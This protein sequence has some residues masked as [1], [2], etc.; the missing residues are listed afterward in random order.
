[1]SKDKEIVKSI[2]AQENI[3]HIIF[4]RL[5]SAQSDL[6]KCINWLCANNQREKELQ[7]N[8]HSAIEVE[9]LKVEE[10]EEIAKITKDEDEVEFDLAQS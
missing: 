6:V 9:D 10:I 1:M 8:C 3:L 7:D 5:K 2:K 4:T